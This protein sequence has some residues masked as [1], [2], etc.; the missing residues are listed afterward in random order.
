MDAVTALDVCGRSV[1]PA[2]YRLLQFLAVQPVSSASTKKSFQ[3]LLKLK[4]LKR[5]TI[6]Q[7]KFTGLT[8]MVMHKSRIKPKDAE[9]ALNKFA[10]KMEEGFLM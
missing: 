8:S 2:I 5:R 9:E 7:E 4:Q 10:Q 6:S 1:Y 3:C